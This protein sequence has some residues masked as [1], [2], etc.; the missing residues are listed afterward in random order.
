VSIVLAILAFLS[1]FLTLW[2]WVAAWRFPLHQRVTD[3][4]FQPAVTLLKP[5]KGLD[6]NTIDCLRSWLRQEYMGT[7]QVL[8]GV[9]SP[10]DPVCELARQLIRE[11]P[12]A[13]A[14]L[15]ICRE[16]L[17][18][19]AKVSSLIQLHRFAKH[20]VIVV[21]DADVLAPTDFLVN[22]VASLRDENVGLV[23]CFY[24]LANPTT[25]GMRW[26]AIAINADF[27][28]Q[29]LQGQ[30]LAPLDFALGAVMVTRRAELAKIGGFESLADHLADDF[31]LGHRIV[32]VPGKRIALCPVVVD[33]VS[34]PMD[35]R[36][37]WD[38]QLRW[39]RTIRVCKPLPYA[40]S[41]LSNAT[42]WPMLWAIFPPDGLAP[43]LFARLFLGACVMI[44][45]IS[46]DAL[47]WRFGKVRG[48]RSFLWLAPIKDLLQVL[49][50][51]GAFCG[52]HIVW[53]G[54][55]YQLQ[56][57]GRLVLHERANS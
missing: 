9:A 41:I 38:H 44:R 15:V 18:V 30:T 12:Q 24:R 35:L 56:R 50:W 32:H 36:E 47:Q 10:D 5:L 4:S 6:V 26:E 45:I 46:A 49:L 29:V 2:Q 43:H 27:W 13:D 19:N 51:I 23:N 3:K 28:S 21:S 42:L 40:A 57:D 34:H 39:A 7:V 11:F 1:L 48:Q 54:H 53:R 33:C 17:G 14:Q 16:A 22:A 8:F 52:N 25:L 55:R 37:T 31:Q 20:E